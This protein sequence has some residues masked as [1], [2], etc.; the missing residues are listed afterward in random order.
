[1]T[2]LQF[3]LDTGMIEIPAEGDIGL[4]GAPG[5]QDFHGLPLERL[6]VI[7]RFKPDVDALEGRGLAVAQGPTGPY[8][9][10]VVSLPRSRDAARS[11]I[12]SAVA[13]TKGPVIID[14]AKTDGVEAVLKAARAMGQVGAAISKSHGKVFVLEGGDFAGWAAGPSQTEEGYWTAPGVFSADGPDPGSVLLAGALPDKIGRIGADLGAGW[15]FLSKVVLSHEVEALHLVE[16]DLTA[17]DCARKN[18][19]EQRANFHW[20]DAKTWVSPDPLDF[21]VMN[22]PF[23]SGRE[24]DIALGQAFISAAARALKPRGTLWLVANRHLRYETHLADAFGQV[25]E[26]GGDPRFKLIEANK[27]KGKR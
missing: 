9:M 15:G 17:L 14:G 5:D 11:R 25:R 2:R 3:A 13:A 6:Q 18:L 20:A 21:V 27:A 19:A 22:P 26:I 7:S 10:S 4:F 16:A 23:H 1:M 8:A 12:A 24:S